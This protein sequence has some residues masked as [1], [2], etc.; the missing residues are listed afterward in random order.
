MSW[1]LVALSMLE[2]AAEDEEEDDMSDEWTDDAADAEEHSTSANEST[3]G[4]LAAGASSIAVQDWQVSIDSVAQWRL[5][6]W[7]VRIVTPEE[8][9]SRSEVT[10]K[11]RARVLLAVS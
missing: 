5:V 9:E 2:E 3:E 6:C 10:E 4:A 7:S 8:H 11:A 1:L